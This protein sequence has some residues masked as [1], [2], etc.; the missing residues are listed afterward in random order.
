MLSAPPISTEILFLDHCFIVLWFNITIIAIVFFGLPYFSFYLWSNAQSINPI[1][2]E[3]MLG[4]GGNVQDVYWID[5]SAFCATWD[6][7]VIKT[8]KGFKATQFWADGS[9]LTQWDRNYNGL[10]VIITTR[11][12]NEK[13]V[14]PIVH[15]GDALQNEYVEKEI[16]CCWLA[17]FCKRGQC[18]CG[19]RCLSGKVEQVAFMVWW[20]IEFDSID[21]Y[22]GKYL[23]WHSQPI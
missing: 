20:L 6:P 7:N 19:E 21:C 23:T 4:V 5:K 14:A 1:E 22:D 12:W 17:W 9:S 3:L 15:Y 2:I 13:E 16:C 18:W 10:M 8:I 11:C